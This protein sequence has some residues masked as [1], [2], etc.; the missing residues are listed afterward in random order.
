MN[1]KH[2][3]KERES[4]P[5][6][7]GMHATPLLIDLFFSCIRASR[8]TTNFYSATHVKREKNKTC[9]LSESIEINQKKQD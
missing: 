9:P 8:N 4:R 3:Q 1:R 7:V 2:G 6:G 5:D